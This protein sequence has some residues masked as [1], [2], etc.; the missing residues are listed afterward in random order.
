M[1]IIK[2][3]ENNPYS[4]QLYDALDAII[5]F[6]NEYLPWIFLKKVYL[7]GKE[8]QLP[9]WITKKQMDI[10]DKDV[11]DLMNELNWEETEEEKINKLFDAGEDDRGNPIF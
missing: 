4:Y 1:K 7:D 8:L 3:D 9:R 10:I 5:F 6:G 11:Q 2:L